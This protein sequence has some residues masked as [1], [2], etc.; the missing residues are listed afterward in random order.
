[1]H[2]KCPGRLFPAVS[3]RLW[4]CSF[5]AEISNVVLWAPAPFLLRLWSIISTRREERGARVLVIYWFLWGRTACM[6]MSNVIYCKAVNSGVF[7]NDCNTA[8]DPSTSTVF[9]CGFGVKS[10]IGI[11]LICEAWLSRSLWQRFLFVFR[12]LA[13]FLARLSV[14]YSDSSSQ[15]S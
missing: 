4:T 10:H 13:V 14:A 9:L 11:T 1:M 6:L 3:S 7:L 8:I 5:E 15:I 2:P 12:C